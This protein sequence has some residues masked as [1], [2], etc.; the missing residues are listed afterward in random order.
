MHSR[1]AAKVIVV[2]KQCL[3]ALGYPYDRCSTWA[4]HMK[5]R[6]RHATED[7][8]VSDDDEEEINL[9]EEIK[10]GYNR[11][12]KRNFVKQKNRNRNIVAI[13]VSKLEIEIPSLEVTPKNSPRSSIDES[14]TLHGTK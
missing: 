11:K 5:L 9:E 6:V 12:V 4:L 14:S 8:D 13:D 2:L 1:C 7:D 3:A 10:E